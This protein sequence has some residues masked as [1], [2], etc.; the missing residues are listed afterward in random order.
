MSVQPPALGTG[1]SGYKEAGGRERPTASGLAPTACARGGPNRGAQSH[2]LGWA[3]CLAPAGLQQSQPPCGPA[4]HPP[5]AGFQECG[6]AAPPRLRPARWDGTTGSSAWWQEEAESTWPHA[7]R[8]GT[9]GRGPC[10]VDSAPRAGCWG[11]L[12]G[13]PRPHGVAPWGPKPS[14]LGRKVLGLKPFEHLL[15][16]RALPSLGASRRRTVSLPRPRHGVGSPRLWRNTVS[17]S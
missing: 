2:A 3:L 13:G 5:A 17:Q 1:V 14:Y 10:P 7:Q 11:L 9:L 6:L 8:V 12:T 15:S 4:S 16:Q